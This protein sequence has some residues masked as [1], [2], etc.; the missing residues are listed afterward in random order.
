MQTIP[1]LI[2][3]ACEALATQWQSLADSSRR[4][5][6]IAAQLAAAIG[7]D[8]APAIRA[9]TAAEEQHV[10]AMVFSGIAQSLVRHMVALLVEAWESVEG[11]A[12]PINLSIP[13][14]IV[15]R[16]WRM[17][18][19][20]GGLRPTTGFYELFEATL[21]RAGVRTATLRE[22]LL[23]AAA[24]CVCERVLMEG[25]TFEYL[26]DDKRAFG[27]ERT[28]TVEVIPGDTLGGARYR[29]GK[30]GERRTGGPAEGQLRPVDLALRQPTAPPPSVTQNT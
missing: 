27:T 9:L 8:A 24:R 30:P 20:S 6:Q 4:E 25:V 7:A 28:F 14:G 12:G 10:N 23:L 21:D 13:E 29:I 5:A 15:R 18:P 17:A 19:H 26:V 16:I 3:L 11:P 2:P 22:P 1:S